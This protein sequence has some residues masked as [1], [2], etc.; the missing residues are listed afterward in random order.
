MKISSTVCAFMSEKESSLFSLALNKLKI[1]TL[2]ELLENSS[3]RKN[4]TVL[5]ESNKT[6][7]HLRCQGFEINLLSQ[8]NLFER[9]EKVIKPNDFLIISGSYPPGFNFEHFNKELKTLKNLKVN[10]FLD[11]NGASMSKIDET[12]HIF[13]KPNLSEFEEYVKE[14][15]ASI[16]E[17]FTFINQDK[18]INKSSLLI[19][20]GSEGMIYSGI[21]GIFHVK[22]NVN[23]ENIV[24][25]V[26]CGDA[27]LAGF[28]FG[29][30]KELDIKLCLKYSIAFAVS[31]L[32]NAKVGN[33][34][35]KNIEELKNAAEVE[36]YKNF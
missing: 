22:L 6:T 35:P 19:T 5:D 36:E 16:Q 12:C 21:E 7:T 26:G 13:M 23:P 25:N 30:I 4:I 1:N 32:G 3:V 24:S 33:L 2:F 34:D 11:N 31:K 10:I 18:K 29:R 14:K 8:K 17:L 28:I 9:I 27:A 20:L 15:F